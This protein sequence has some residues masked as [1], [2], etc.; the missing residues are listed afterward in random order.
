MYATD[1]ASFGFYRL[2]IF[3]TLNTHPVISAD[4][5]IFTTVT[6]TGEFCGTIRF[7]EPPAMVIDFTIKDRQPD[8]MLTFDDFTDSVDQMNCGAR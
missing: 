3:C 1:S 4:S 5:Q 8:S 6:I 2:Q 7:D